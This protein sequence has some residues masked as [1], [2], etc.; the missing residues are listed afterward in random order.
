METDKPGEEDR[1]TK[2]DLQT[3]GHA[4]PSDLPTNTT[5][6]PSSYQSA[7]YGK[8]MAQ[9]KQDKHPIKSKTVW[10]IVAWVLG[11][12]GVAF[13]L[14][15]DTFA[16]LADGIQLVDIGAIIAILGIAWKQYGQRVAK[17][18]LTTVFGNERKQ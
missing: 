16:F 6:E 1:P 17:A 10:G 14:P 11:A 12:L 4:P 7:D 13:G 18:A 8:L 9:V 3:P 2:R 15:D 5:A